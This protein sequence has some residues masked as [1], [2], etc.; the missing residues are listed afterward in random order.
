MNRDVIHDWGEGIYWLV[1]AKFFWNDE[2]KKMKWLNKTVT[3]LEKAYKR[4]SENNVKSKI[5]YIGHVNMSPVYI[6][7]AYAVLGKRQDC[8]FWMSCGKLNGLLPETEKICVMKEFQEYLKDQVFLSI[9]TET[10]QFT[11]DRFTFYVDQR[12]HIEKEKKDLDKHLNEGFS[13]FLTE[14]AL[15]RAS[16]SKT[17][18]NFLLENSLRLPYGLTRRSDNTLTAKELLDKRMNL[19]GIETKRPIP[20][21]G[22]CQFYSLSDQLCGKLDHAGFLR[23]SIVHW[24]RNNGDLE[25]SNGAKMKDFA[26]DRTWEQYCNEMDRNGTW[27]DHLTLI[28]ATEIFSIQIF[29]ISSVTGDNFIVDIVPEKVRPHRLVMLSHYAE[30]HYGSVQHI[31]PKLRNNSL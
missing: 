23:K 24:L 5:W 8:F 14:S 30:C 31:D 4:N 20:G 2:E 21:D 29:I 27:G 11:K 25:L 18:T 22:N 1:K 3:L 15:F 17:C 7:R 13:P 19:Y 6:A 10:M 16:V 9:L 12:I 26:H 28:A